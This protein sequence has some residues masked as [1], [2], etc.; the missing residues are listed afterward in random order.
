[1][2]NSLMATIKGKATGGI[3]DVYHA[4]RGKLQGAHH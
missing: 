1:M 4:E 3:L 2:E